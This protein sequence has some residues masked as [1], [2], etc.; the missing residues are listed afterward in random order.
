MAAVAAL[1][2]HA[3][4]RPVGPACG[5]LVCSGRNDLRFAI[6]DLSDG[7]GGWYLVTYDR[8]TDPVNPPDGGLDI[9]LIHLGDDLRPVPIHDGPGGD[10]PCGALLVGGAGTQ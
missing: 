2:A 3:G 9:G 5:T 7:A 10:D 4:M 8:M 6:A 1:P